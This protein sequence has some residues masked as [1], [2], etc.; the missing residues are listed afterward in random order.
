MTDSAELKFISAPFSLKSV[1]EGARTFKGLSSTWDEDLG[2]DVI[3]EGAF[4]RTIDHFKASGR[5]IPLMDGHPEGEGLAGQRVRRVIG[6]VIDA[7]ESKAGVDTQFEMV[8]DDDDAAAAMRRVKG[9]FV[10][11]LSIY[12]KATRAEREKPSSTHP[13]GRRHIHELKWGSVGLVLSGMN[14]RATADPLS[15]KS[16][17]AA[18]EADE[19]TDEQKAALMALPAEMKSVLRALLDDPPAP[20]EIA[21]AD[22]PKGLAPDDP[23]RIELA[24]RLR[25]LKLRRLAFAK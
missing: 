15:V 3:H 19:L 12:Y 18:L 14:P 21:P 2:G 1:D 10:T 5:V 23:R 25:G 6:K 20:L 22:T 9:R 11:D 13:R 7:G 16:L 4:A 8:P 17:V 24:A